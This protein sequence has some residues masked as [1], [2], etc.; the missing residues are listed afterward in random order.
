M[1]TGQGP[2]VR[3]LEADGPS[4]RLTVGE[5]EEALWCASHPIIW[6]SWSLQRG[7]RTIVT[8][9]RAL[10]ALTLLLASTTSALGEAQRAVDA[11][12]A[13]EL[14]DAWQQAALTSGGRLGLASDGRRGLP[15]SVQFAML[16]RA[17]ATGGVLRLPLP[18]GDS[19]RLA[20]AWA[21]FE[22]TEG[23]IAGPLLDTEGEASLTI[24]GNTLSGRIVANGRLFMIRRVAETDTHVVNQIDPQ[25]LPPEAPPLEPPLGAAPA[26]LEDAVVQADT[27]AFV[28]LM[29]VY[30]PAARSQIGGT[31]AMVAELIGAVNN[32]NVALATAGVVHRFRLVHYQEIAYAETGDMEVS[33]RRLTTSGDGYMDTVQALRDL[34]RADVV[35][36]FTT[37]MNACGLGWVMTTASS[38][39]ER[40]AYNVSL[41]SCANAGL[42]LAHEIGH[43]M[44][45]MHDRGNSGT[46]L[47]ASPYGYGYR[48]SGV[49]RDVM[50]YECPT[51][52]C[53]RRAIFST[54]RAYFPGTSQPAGTLNDD[55]TRA[56]NDWSLLVA[57]FRQS[58][59]PP[60]GD[61]DATCE[62]GD[63]L[64]HVRD[65]LRGGDW[66]VT[67]L[68]VVSGDERD[69][70]DADR[71]GHGGLL[72]DAGTDHHHGLL[73]A[74]RERSRIN[75]F[76]H[77]DDHDQ[78][79]HRHA[80]NK[81]AGAMGGNYDAERRRERIGSAGL[82]V[83]P[84][85]ERRHEHAN[86][87][88]NGGQLHHAPAHSAD[89]YLGAREQRVWFRGLRDGDGEPRSGRVRHDAENG[90]RW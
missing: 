24:V 49:A 60:T 68:R 29:I 84:G 72:H 43:N 77:G 15:V 67:G 81:P 61:Y 8:C 80:A 47:P 63:S 23:L 58:I 64:G 78:T 56:L 59:P 34:H 14:G 65:A 87:W 38:A 32:T 70:D 36:L 39:F 5:A 42:T 26:A 82:P 12:A 73:G 13:E 85:D 75:E 10:V 25:S 3:T 19:V 79:S 18:D 55:A 1:A 16:R 86:R 31:S 28:D 88:C 66:A 69:Y 90:F 37:D 22:D 4:A 45:L 40:S 52:G 48:I 89:E 11:S 30:T 62:P 21:Q 2:Y 57:N 7:A 17:A 6:I 9:A 35:S 71:G 54:P 76:R 83:V 20:I 50:A 74:G 33:L 46:S 53:P 27:N 44:G 51:V 41:W